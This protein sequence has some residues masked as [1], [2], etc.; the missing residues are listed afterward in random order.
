MPLVT[1]GFGTPFSFGYMAIKRRSASL[2]VAT[3]VYGAVVALMVVAPDASV[4]AAIAGLVWM[5]AW[6]GATIHAFALRPSLFPAPEPPT[7]A[8]VRNEQAVHVVKYRRKLRAEARALA[9]EDPA[10][11]Y[12]LRIGRPDLPRA[13]DD[14]GLVD[15]NSAPPGVLAGLPGMTDELVERIVARRSEEGGFLSAEEMAVE[16]DLP[17]A[18]FQRVA[19][20][21]LF[22]P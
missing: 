9:R 3:A 22:M 8:S 17:P 13:Y 4:F 11:A 2:A 5:M 18:V 7:P 16:I 6:I 15:V 12:E 1:F 21:T 10:L 19:D 20:L 14:G